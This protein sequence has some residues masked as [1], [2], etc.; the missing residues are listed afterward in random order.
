ME[1]PEQHITEKKSQRIFENIVPVEW[2]CRDIK[3][4]YGVDYLVEV[5]ENNQSTGKTFFVQLKG[6]TQE[7]TNNTFEKQF[8]VKN[9]EYYSSLSI[10]VM[11]ICVSVTDSKIW[12]IWA[13]RLLD[14]ITLKEN[15][16]S[17]LIKLGKEY[18]LNE[19]KFLK[20]VS[21]SAL[22]KKLGINANTSFPI[23]ERLNNNLVKWLE[24]KFTESVSTK[25]TNLPTHLNLDYSIVE[26]GDLSLK[27][28]TPT[29]SK[30]LIIKNLKDD[31]PFLYRP[32][33]DS[34]DINEYNKD[35]LFFIA[36][37][38]AKHDI[39]GSLEILIELISEVDFEDKEKFLSLDPFG[40]LINAQLIN[41]VKLYNRLLEKII[42]LN[43]IDLFSIF[44]LA[45][46]YVNPTRYRHYRI[47]NLKSVIQKNDEPKFLATCYYNLG[48]ILRE[49]LESYEPFNC[50]IKAKKLWP[51]YLERDYW[52]REFAGIIFA[53]KHYAF[54]EKFYKKSQTLVKNKGIGKK[55]NRLERVDSNETFL[56]NALIADCLFFQ[57]KFKD[58]HSYFEQ[59]FNNNSNSSQEW[60]LKD[61]ICI[62]LM[63]GDLNNLTF[64]REQSLL[65]CEQGLKASSTDDSIEK[66]EESIK[67]NPLNGLSWFNLGVSKDKKGL[68]EEALFAFITTSMIQ[69]WDKEA[70]FNAITI[71]YTQQN[72]D[73]LQVMLLFIFEKHGEFVINDLTDYI[74]QKNLPLENKTHLVNGFTEM[75]EVIK[76]VAQ[77]RI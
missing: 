71:C 69:E 75:F 33:F 40:L 13:N 51:N 9:L 3:P 68:N 1:R 12:G 14:S 65:L 17:T 64:N 38:M 72:F 34:E 22:S 50:Y 55:Y 52:W 8:T 63:N 5:F 25:F 19:E 36:I 73:L 7:I 39:K 49:N 28:T 48:N 2:V 16:K 62:E 57:G 53:K 30:E 31:N 58:A 27:I 32:H 70:Q 54:S 21:E 15:Q 23:A 77:Q 74:M 60:I 18:L 35:A 26:N 29:F 67:S 24:H 59:Y 44:N 11:I 76:N 42:Q 20:L 43:L 56:V 4:D 47:Q 6:S 45:Y 46:F 37:A 61:M 41:E 10:P 66:F